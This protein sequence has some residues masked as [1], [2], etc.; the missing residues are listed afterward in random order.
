[1]DIINT[2]LDAEF[3]LD[4]D[5]FTVTVLKFGFDEID[6]LGDEVDD[7]TVVVEPAAFDASHF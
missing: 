2:D 5:V 1:M 4:D 7:D 3:A 6:E